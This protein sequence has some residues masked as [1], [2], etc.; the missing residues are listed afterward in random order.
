MLQRKSDGRVL[1]QNGWLPIKDRSN[2]T[3]FVIDR[4][5]NKRATTGSI[6]ERLIK[7]SGNEFDTL[8]RTQLA[9]FTMFGVDEFKDYPAKYNCKV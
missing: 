6:R 4:C 5:D 2:N 7:M 1:T 8:T 9:K 3:I